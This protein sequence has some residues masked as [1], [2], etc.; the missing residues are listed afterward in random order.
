GPLTWNS[1]HVAQAADALAYGGIARF[2]GIRAALAV[3]GNTGENQPGI[4]YLETLWPKSP[5]FQCAGSEIF[6]QHV[7]AI[8]QPGRQLAAVIALQIHGD[9]SFIAPDTAPP[10]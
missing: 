3:A 9:G 8:D 5:V 7:G 10:E 4:G 1:V 2:T 6:D